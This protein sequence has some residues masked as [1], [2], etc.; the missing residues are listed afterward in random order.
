MPL[1]V[2]IS[3]FV[4]KL[5]VRACVNCEPSHL[6]FQHSFSARCI[7]IQGTYGA[8]RAPGIISDSR[9][10]QLTWTAVLSSPYVQGGIWRIRH[11]SYAS[12][13]ELSLDKA[14]FSIHI[15]L[16]ERHVTSDAIFTSFEELGGDGDHP[17][18]RIPNQYS[19]QRCV[20]EE[21]TEVPK[22]PVTPRSTDTIITETLPVL[23][24]RAV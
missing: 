19:I 18:P 16:Q 17:H 14:S 10:I 24:D 20:E 13:Q 15:S 3:L 22:A 1:Y 6:W 4:T 8:E 7:C 11:L 2:G 12:P 21:G 23:S 9:R 5:L